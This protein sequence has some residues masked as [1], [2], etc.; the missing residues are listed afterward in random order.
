MT[1][2]RDGKPITESFSERWEIEDDGYR[3]LLAEAEVNDAARY[4]CLAKNVA[5]QNEKYYDLSVLGE[6]DFI[7]HLFQFIS[8][9][10]F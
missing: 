3:I 10:Y 7:Y 8:S 1:W 6:I 2:F 5:G 4:S 9:I